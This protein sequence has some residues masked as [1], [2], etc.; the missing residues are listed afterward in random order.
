MLAPPPPP[1]VV[2]LAA[3][4]ALM[5]CVASCGLVTSFGDY[6]TSDPAN[7]IGEAGANGD[8]SGPTFGVSGVLDGLDPSKKVTLLLNGT[9]AVTVP[10][11]HFAFPAVAADGATYGVTVKSDP[12]W[13]CSVANG[14]GTI[15][16]KDVTSVAVRCLSTDATL[17]GLSVSAGSLVPAFNSAV[18]SYSI[19]TPTKLVPIATSSVTAIPS[20]PSARVTISPGSPFTVVPG[21]DAIDVL[22]TP[23]DPAAKP[24]HYSVALSATANVD[25]LKASN[26]RTTGGARFGSTIAIAGDTLVVG[27]PYERSSATGVNCIGS[28]TCQ[29]DNSTLNAGAAYV[30]RRTGSTWAQEAYLKASNTAGNTTFGSAVAIDGDTIV[31]G[32]SGESSNATGVDG[33]Q[34]NSAASGSGAAY[35]FTRTGATWSQQAYLKASNARANAKFGSSVGISGDIAIVGA[36][37]EASN[38]TGVNCTTPG[39]QQDTSVG[40]AGAVYVFARTGTSWMQEAYVKASTAS[41]GLFGSA[42]AISNNTI[43]VGARFESSKAIGVNGDPNDASVNGAGAAWVFTRD[44]GVWSQQAYL[45]SSARSSASTG[46]QFGTS[47]A[48]AGD[49]IAVGAPVEPSDATGVNCTPA[50]ACEAST[51]ANQSGAAYVFTRTGTSWSQAAYIK[52][53]RVN[54]GAGL[55]QSVALYGDSLAVGA[56]D[57]S[58]FATGLNG[59]QNDIPSASS[60]AVYFFRRAGPSWSQADYIKATNTRAKSFFGESVALSADTLAV[61]ASGESSNATGING[62]Q[63]DTSAPTAGAVYVY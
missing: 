28:A 4:V 21:A 31:V 36:P 1:R 32:A 39:C 47:V 22:V 43:V 40:T 2:A 34:S 11:G 52:A 18:R 26:T 35:V 30:F 50:P 6:D 41:S 16:G 62:N 8:A 25:Y 49:S 57:E 29:A 27:A 15:A 58:N 12:A 53:S 48:I 61:G 54:P 13:A 55:G 5:G 23:A 63:A 56:V 33:D 3:C 37:S 24:L 38:A 44:A 51:A 17:G 10:N 9:N 46:P 19:T 42:I 20:S 7:R 60:G 14:T 59:N 45:K